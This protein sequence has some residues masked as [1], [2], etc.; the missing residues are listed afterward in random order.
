[1]ATNERRREL[2]APIELRLEYK[3]LNAFFADY[4]RNISHGGTFVRTD[5][6]LPVGTEFLFELGIPHLP[7]P[8]KL[9]G[10]VQWIISADD[11]PQDAEPGMGIGFVFRSEAERH[12]VSAVVEKLMVES[13][14]RALYDRLVGDRTRED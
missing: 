13:L 9:R 14:G 5:Q 4:A 8:L 12:R 6:P 2:R 7:E 11:V 1:M 10:R 3:Q